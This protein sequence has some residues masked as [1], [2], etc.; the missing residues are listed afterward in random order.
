MKYIIAYIMIG[1]A[2]IFLVLGIERLLEIIPIKASMTIF[3][4]CIIILIIL[5]LI[6]LAFS[7]YWFLK[8]NAGYHFSKNHEKLWYYMHI[9]AFFGGTILIEFFCVILPMIS[10]DIKSNRSRFGMY[11]VVLVTGILFYMFYKYGKMREEYHIMKITLEMEEEK[12]KVAYLSESRL[13]E[14]IAE[15]KKRQKELYGICS[16]V[17]QQELYCLDEIIQVVEN[18]IKTF[19]S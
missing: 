14:K 18:K 3:V 9:G 2:L 5:C 12:K 8:P 17:Q 10:G 19:K 1:I 4:L 7:L 11:V 13:K 16:P 6:S 15:F